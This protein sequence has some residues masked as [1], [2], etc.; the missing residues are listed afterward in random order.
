MNSIPDLQPCRGKQC[1]I[2]WFRSRYGD[3]LLSL[4]YLRHIS[5]LWFISTVENSQTMSHLRCGLKRSIK[6]STRVKCSPCSLNYLSLCLG[7]QNSLWLS[8]ATW[9]NRICCGFTVWYGQ[10][11][12]N[13]NPSH[14][15]PRTS[16]K[17]QRGKQTAMQ[18]NISAF[19]LRDLSILTL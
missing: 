16:S 5:R 3:L 19:S 1:G 17:I 2:T 6:D 9:Y 12:R 18:I 11:Q 15:H 4:T 8:R 13:V 7:E 10:I 14:A